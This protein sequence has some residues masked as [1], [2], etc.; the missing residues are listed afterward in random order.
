M[1]HPLPYPLPYLGFVT[2]AIAPGINSHHIPVFFEGL[3]LMPPAVPALRE[4]MEKQ[5]QG[6]GGLTG[7]R[8]YSMQPQG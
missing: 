6:L 3:H 4:A 8:G 5:Q 1:P 7:P 2:V